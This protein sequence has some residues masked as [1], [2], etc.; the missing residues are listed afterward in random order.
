M[1]N[2]LYIL[3]GV[4]WVVY[5]LYTARQKALK[6]QQSQEIPPRGPSQS[7]PLPLPGS[8]G[9]T[10]FDEI[11]REL[12]GEPKPV[13]QT[14]QPAQPSV[15]IP[16]DMPIQDAGMHRNS[17][18]KANISS[19]PTSLARDASGNDSKTL[20]NPPQVAK[21]EGFPKKFD[22]REAVIF[23]ELLNRKYF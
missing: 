8:G 20:E 21:N 7:S 5:S 14:Y 16:P 9:R 6:R 11:F 23:S 10:L 12:S 13:I 1:E 22:L 3:I 4:I 18:T 17:F 19:L 15:V 2:F